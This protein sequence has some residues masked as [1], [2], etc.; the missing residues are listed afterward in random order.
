MAFKGKYG[1]PVMLFLAVILLLVLMFSFTPVTPYSRD[2]LFRSYS[3]GYEAFA[4]GAE[5]EEHKDG[6][7]A[8]V[9]ENSVPVI[10]NA[11]P[12]NHLTASDNQKEQ[13]KPTN[14]VPPKKESFEPMSTSS[15]LEFG[16]YNGEEVIDKFSTLGNDPVNGNCL[17]AGLSNSKGPL[18][19]TPELI[20]DLK[21]RGNNM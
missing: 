3:S 2:D 5:T 7:N 6:G 9:D 8:V 17:S 11:E 10:E 1:V 12:Q 19:L 18:C 4:E 14:K 15:K 20:H 21:T 16:S 13:S